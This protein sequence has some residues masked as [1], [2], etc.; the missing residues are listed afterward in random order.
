MDSSTTDESFKQRHRSLIRSRP[1]AGPRRRHCLQQLEAQVQEAQSFAYGRAT[2]SEDMSVVKARRVHPTKRQR[3]AKSRRPSIHQRH[4]TSLLLVL[5]LLLLCQPHS[6]H[7][8]GGGARATDGR[9][10]TFSSSSSGEDRHNSGNN[11]HGGQ[12]DNDRDSSHD[13]ASAVVICSVDGTVYTLDPWS[14][15]LRGIFASGP[16]L[17]SSS[18]DND[19]GSKAKEPNNNDDDLDEGDDDAIL[20]DDDEN[21]EETLFG[22]DDGDDASSA[23]SSSARKQNKE[24]IVPG[25]D[26]N[27]YSLLP[28]LPEEQSAGLRLERLPI[29]VADAVESPIS[30]CSSGGTTSNQQCSLVM[31]EKQTK[32]FRLD[33]ATGRVVWMQRPTGKRGGFTA[34]DSGMLPAPR[35]DGGDGGESAFSS[36]SVLLQREDYLLRSVD[37]D[38]GEE[39]WNV[40]LGRFSA[41]DFGSRGRGDNTGSGRQSGREGGVKTSSSDSIGKD[42]PHHMPELPHRL[43]NLDSESIHINEETVNSHDF[44]QGEPYMLGVEPLPSVAFGDEGTTIIAISSTGKILWQR[45]MDSVVAA[46]YGVEQHGHGGKASGW[47]SLD[48]IEDFNIQ[49]GV[50]GGPLLESGDEKKMLPPPHAD[51]PPIERLTHTSSTRFDTTRDGDSIPPTISPGTQEEEDVDGHRRSSTALMPYGYGQGVSFATTF[52]EFAQMFCESFYSHIQFQSLLNALSLQALSGAAFISEP[53]DSAAGTLS[54]KQARIGTHSS[55]I[56]VASTSDSYPHRENLILDFNF[57]DTCTDDEDDDDGSCA[58]DDGFLFASESSI[59]TDGL[60]TIAIE[61]LLLEHGLL[62]E[63]A[64]AADLQTY[65]ALYS[66]MREAMKHTHRNNH[67]LFLSWRIVAILACA[68]LGIVLGIRVGYNRQKKIWAT[69]MQSPMLNGTLTHMPGSASPRSRQDS[70]SSSDLIIPLKHV[71]S[72]PPLTDTDLPRSQ[73]QRS[74]VHRSLSMPAMHSSDPKSMDIGDAHREHTIDIKSMAEKSDVPLLRATTIATNSATATA[75][76]PGATV[77]NAAAAMSPIAYTDVAVPESASKEMRTADNLDGIPLVRYSRYSSEFQELSPLGRGGFGTVFQCMNALDGRLYAIKKIWIKTQVGADGSVGVHFKEKLHRVLRE[78]KILALLDH[79]NIVRYYTAWLELEEGNEGTAGDVPTRGFPDTTL[80]RCYSSDLLTGASPGVSVSSSIGPMMGAKSPLHKKMLAKNP[81]GWNNFGSFDRGSSIFETSEEGDL[82]SPQNFRRQTSDDDLGFTWERSSSGLSLDGS[83]S[84][85]RSQILKGG[86]MT[87]NLS[88]VGDD[89]KEE[90]ESGTSSDESSSDDSSSS[91]C[92]HS[93]LSEIDEGNQVMPVP[94]IPRST[95]AFEETKECSSSKPHQEEQLHSQ[96][97]ILYIQMQLCSQK[98]LADFLSNPEARRG[99]GR[100]SG[101]EE[102]VATNAKKIIGGIDL[103]HALHLFTQIARGVK[104]VHKQG[105]IHRDLKPLNCFIDEAGNVKIGD[106]GLSRESANADA[107]AAENAN[108]SSELDNS[109]HNRRASLGAGEDN[110][111]G[112]GTKSYMSP[113]QMNGSDY[114]ASTDIYSLGIILFELCYPMYTVME[115]H[116]VVGK[117]RERAF[118]DQWKKTVA[119]TFPS[120]NELLLEMLSPNPEDRPTSDAVVD[121]VDTLL[122]EYTCDLLG[123]DFSMYQKLRQLD[124]A[125]KESGRQ[126]SSSMGAS[127]TEEQIIKDGS[128]G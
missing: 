102:D 52:A 58:K 94:E 100:S 126:R 3:S 40:T 35:N 4:R 117:L 55:T 119:A 44:G 6:T 81:L 38:T 47:S 116:K 49:S 11:D 120:L 42:R 92:S 93:S 48:V 17:I 46:V 112:V 59:S 98:T 80:G 18:T 111:A 83:G 101:D 87:S 16:A 5:F 69:Q 123:L 7:A 95:V 73:P 56:F 2:D 63:G 118:P 70:H 106:F 20:D 113:E 9:P 84:I 34:A 85:R 125:T 14:G 105:L 115:R 12:Q 45:E 114:D 41:L 110:T 77:A 67:G 127:A 97:H 99:D 21:Q 121:R 50:K 107:D 30:T 109:H 65:S 71:D 88:V 22:W 29:S 37:A 31:G 66:S 79:P 15:N 10:S 82:N 8:G 51:L 68:V 36:T 13:S 86:K 108:E 90:D 53:A 24:R 104:H 25:L 39:R 23:S 19:D 128:D 62:P 26:G 96:R 28:P 103:P 57:D 27:L 64:N 60:D 91:S 54:V 78:V 1:G 72:V 32:I 74:P 89:E 61:S 124:R 43:T 75:T 122:G 33:T 76:A